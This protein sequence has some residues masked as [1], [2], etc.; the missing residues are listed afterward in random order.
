[1]QNRKGRQG[2]K[3]V[4]DGEIE[5]LEYQLNNSGLKENTENMRY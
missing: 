3:R 4:T 1:M 5:F 2:R